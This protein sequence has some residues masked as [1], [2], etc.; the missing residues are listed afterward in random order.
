MLLLTG[1]AGL[2][3]SNVLQALNDRGRD[4]IIC[5]DDL[6]NGAKCRNLAGKKFCRYVDHREVFELSRELF[7]EIVHF[8]ANVD[9]ACNDGRAM[10]RDNYDASIALYKH[11]VLDNPES[12]FVYA[13]TAGVYGWNGK[14]KTSGF[15]ED[16]ACEAPCSPY[17]FSKWLLDGYM[18]IEL[19]ALHTMSITGLR[20]FNVY[21]PGEQHKGRMR[22]AIGSMLNDIYENRRPTLFDGSEWIMRDFVWVGDAVKA[23]LWALDNRPRGIFNVGTGVARSFEDAYNAVAAAAAYDGR[24]QYV[25]FP[26]DLPNYQYFTKAD[27]TNLRAAGFTEEFAPLEEGV[28][29]YVAQYH[30]S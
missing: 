8:G 25:D 16:P 30:R 17:A 27:L 22:S 18:R 13:S 11:F 6:T 15:C 20:F 4:D 10:V 5:V 1:A 28:K 21:G 9:T 2:I 23:V 7:S 3:G 26:V 29:Q 24:P 19:R 12:T 14:S